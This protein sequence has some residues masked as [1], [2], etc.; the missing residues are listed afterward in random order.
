[1]FTVQA[2]NKIGIYSSNYPHAEDYDLFFRIAKYW[3]IANLNKHVLLY[4][5]SD[6]SISQEHRFQQGV[7]ILKIFVKNF[8]WRIYHSYIGIVLKLFSLIIPTNF[9]QSIKKF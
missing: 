7:S 5:Y 4:E 6:D 3:K 8:D 2:I 1:M 9:M